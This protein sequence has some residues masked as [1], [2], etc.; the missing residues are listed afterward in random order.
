MSTRMLS[1][2][3]IRFDVDPDVPL[4]VAAQALHEQARGRAA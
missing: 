2:L 4:L 1:A 3:T